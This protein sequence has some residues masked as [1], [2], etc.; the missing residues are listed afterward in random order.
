MA[1][2]PKESYDVQERLL[3]AYK[4]LLEEQINIINARLHMAK[5]L[6]PSYRI[7]LLNVNIT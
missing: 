7:P 6:K 3:I 2:I 1:E 5:R 4:K